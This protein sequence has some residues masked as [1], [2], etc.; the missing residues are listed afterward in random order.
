[1]APTGPNPVYYSRNALFPASLAVAGE[2][3]RVR[4]YQFVSVRL[5]PVRYNPVTRELFL[6]TRLTLTIRYKAAARAAAYYSDRAGGPADLFADAVLNLVIN[7]GQ[8]G[9]ADAHRP[10]ASRSDVPAAAVDY[11]IITSTALSNSFQAL[12][13]HRASVNALSTRIITTET[14]DA[15]YDGTRPDGGSDQQTR[16]RNCVVDFVR[17]HGATYVILG[18]DNTIVP[19]RDCYVSCGSYTCSDMPTDLYYGGLDSSWDENANGVYGEANYSGGVADEGDL[20]FDVIVARLPIRTAAQ[21]DAYIN[22]LK[23][24]ELNNPPLGF[25]KR[26]IMLGD[27]LWDSYSGAGRPSDACVDGHSE[28]QQHDPVSDDEIWM[29]R[30]VRDGIRSNFT[31]VAMSYF[32][33]SLTS[34]DSATPGD[35]LQSSANVSARFNQGW[36]NVYFG[37]HGSYTSWGL[38]S[39]SFGTSSAAAL[40]NRTALVYT[41]ACLTGGF[42][43]ADPS[44]SE[45]FLRNGSGGALVYMGCSRYGWGSP[46][47]WRGGPSMDYAYEY[48]R[49]VY[50]LDRPSVGRAFAEHKL[51]RAAYCTYNGADRWVQFG[52]NLQGDP[53]VP[54]MKPDIVLG[55]DPFW[56]NAMGLTN[57]VYLRWPNPHTCGIS[58]QTVMVRSRTDRYP[59]NLTDGTLLYTGTN[60]VY[61]HSALTPG[62]PRYY[63]IW[64]SQDGVNF[65][66]PPP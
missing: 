24:F 50:V 59:T 7:P 41:M 44:L 58:N 21:A 46:G 36:N 55:D 5:N 48:Y 4:G 42:D 18:G 62:Q 17:N 11:L 8:P 22:K 51:A 61:Q 32:F 56:F 16:I 54:L 65:I 15:T 28:F 9:W 20:G 3:H 53:L 26:F 25:A 13:S 60:T 12:A 31:D 30:M 14:I 43:A 57:S 27:M 10:A 34:W 63:T 35:Y 2:T 52:M 38:E 1:M 49:Q 6:A 64:V 37:T 19:D 47:S 33:D 39:G 29:R 45:A 66:D 23:D 40:T